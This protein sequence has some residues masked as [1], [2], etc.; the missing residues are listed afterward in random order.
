MPV[1]IQI[2]ENVSPN[3]EPVKPVNI[4]EKFPY[5]IEIS[6]KNESNN[7]KTDEKKPK[8]NGNILRKYS[9]NFRNLFYLQK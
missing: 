4:T 3:G 6:D 1:K 2:K 5:S 9:L 7:D 8:W